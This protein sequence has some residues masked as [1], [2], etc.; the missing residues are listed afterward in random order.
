[1]TLCGACLPGTSAHKP[2]VYVAGPYQHPDPVTNTQAAIAAANL[3]HD[4]GLVTP[5]VP[6][7][8]LLWHMHTPRPVEFW[9][10]YD[11]EV[12]AHCHALLRIPGVSLGADLEVEFAV[13]HG[14]R[15]FDSVADVNRHYFSLTRRT[16]SPVQ[17]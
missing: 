15:V 17:S 5:V 1:M 7:L 9:Y 13:K 3:L 6:H 11:L 16:P 8:S 12:L 10:A 4:G 2:L 14:I